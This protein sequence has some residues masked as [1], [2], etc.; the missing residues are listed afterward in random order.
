MTANPTLDVVMKSSFPNAK[1]ALPRPLTNTTRGAID[2]ANGRKYVRGVA[3]ET[4]ECENVQQLE[5][6]TQ[7]ETSEI[8]RL[9]Y[10]I[11]LEAQGANVSTINN[12]QNITYGQVLG[13]VNSQSDYAPDTQGP[14]QNL[15]PQ[16][17]IDLPIPMHNPVNTVGAVAVISSKPSMSQMHGIASAKKLTGHPG[18]MYRQ[19]AALAPAKDLSIEKLIGKKFLVRTDILQTSKVVSSKFYDMTLNSKLTSGTPGSQTI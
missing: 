1:F 6:W 3:L 15:T 5:E 12:V 14:N 13:T 4:K 10:D 19:G 17:K 7:E 9:N 2:F 18:Q 11:D 16:T 8:E